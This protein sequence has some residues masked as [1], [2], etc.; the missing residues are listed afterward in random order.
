M[1]DI[2]SSMPHAELPLMFER[3]KLGTTIDLS[4][5]FPPPCSE[6]FVCPPCSRLIWGVYQ[7]AWL[8]PVQ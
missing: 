1:N 7:F 5:G 4:K 3:S 8:S 6:I 2:V